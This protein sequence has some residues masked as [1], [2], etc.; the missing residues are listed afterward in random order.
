MSLSRSE[1][2]RRMEALE[3][4]INNAE[5]GRVT[6]P[7]EP[8]LRK[9]RAATKLRRL[10]SPGQIMRF[11]TEADWTSFKERFNV[12][13]DAYV[14]IEHTDP[15]GFDGDSPTF[16]PDGADNPRN[17]LRRNQLPPLKI[18][19]T[20]VYNPSVLGEAANDEA[21]DVYM[22]FLGHLNGHY[23]P[24]VKGPAGTL[25]ARRFPVVETLL[26]R[27]MTCAE[28]IKLAQSNLWYGATMC[29]LVT[30]NIFQRW[31]ASVP[32]FYLITPPSASSPIPQ[33]TD[34]SRPTV[35]CFWFNDGKN[36][37][38]ELPKDPDCRVGIIVQSKKYVL[39]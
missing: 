34:C 18:D 19:M 14:L 17:Y 29:V 21:N 27:V 26:P 9:G 8:P 37:Q 4:A 31:S 10:I 25:V 20:N 33:S 36:G 38:I 2:L 3:R 7:D 24:E 35:G 6:V 13:D 15:L 12:L 30:T 16:Y 11:P 5:R 32:R 22:P 23:L 1:L 28:A 39:L